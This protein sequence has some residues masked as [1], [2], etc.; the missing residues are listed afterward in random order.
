[1]RDVVDD[2]QEG[3]VDDELLA[4]INHRLGVLE[5]VNHRLGLL[6][7]LNDRF[8]HVLERLEESEVDRDTLAGIAANLTGIATAVADRFEAAEARLA[9]TEARLVEL[10]GRLD[11]PG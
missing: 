11:P 5:Q 10:A 2:E 4:E 8:Q 1:M 6:E 3:P 7:E 9:A